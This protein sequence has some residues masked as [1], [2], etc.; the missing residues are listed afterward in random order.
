MNFDALRSEAS[1]IQFFPFN[2]EQKR[3]GVAVKSVMCLPF[4]IILVCGCF[5][6]VNQHPN[7]L[8][9]QFQPDSS[10]H[11]HWKGAAEIVLGSCTH[12]MDENASL[13]EMSGDK[14]NNRVS[15]YHNIICRKD[16]NISLCL[17]SSFKTVLL[18]F[19]CF[20]F[21]ILKL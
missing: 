7:E 3:G 19:M 1:A 2:S 8:L 13:A 18:L 10:V 15:L 16:F 11:V 14:V 5:T 12:Y 6:L 17:D 4:L 21:T 20:F 9:T